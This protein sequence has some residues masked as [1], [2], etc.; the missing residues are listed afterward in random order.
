MTGQKVKHNVSKY[1]SKILFESSDNEK[2]YYDRIF[3]LYS[4]RSQYIH[5]NEPIEITNEM[6]FELREI[7]REVLWL[8]WNISQ[9][10]EIN[11]ASD[12]IKF[13]DKNNQMT[14]DLQLQAFKKYLH[15]TNSRALYD[16]IRQKLLNG[17][18]NILINN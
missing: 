9:Y 13:L 3:Y 14:I 5:G 10:Y 8:Y 17:K 11:G 16:E 7:V 18:T 2:E 1:S 6:E 15:V 4:V 12:V